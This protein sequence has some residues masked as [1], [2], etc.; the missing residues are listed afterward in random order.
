[1]D[2]MDP[3]LRCPIKAVKLKQSLTHHQGLYPPQTQLSL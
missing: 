3:D 1:M 2:Y